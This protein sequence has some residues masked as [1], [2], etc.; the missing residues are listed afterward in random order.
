[1]QISLKAKR[2]FETVYK[3]LL[4]IV[5]CNIALRCLLV[6]NTHKT[7]GRYTHGELAAFKHK[8]LI[9]EVLNGG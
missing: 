7:V 9:E 8:Q 6:Y 2:Q 4:E 1:V 3:M 5:P